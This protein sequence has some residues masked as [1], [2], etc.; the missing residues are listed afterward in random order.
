MITKTKEVY[1]CEYCKRHGLS[2]GAMRHH[3]KIC[4]ENP[5]NHRPCFRCKYL[6]KGDAIAHS[7]STGGGEYTHN[8][9]VLKCSVRNVF[10]YTPIN[11]IKGNMFNLNEENET[12]PIECNLFDTH[13]NI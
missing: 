12:M 7:E 3:E 8:V 6:T 2:K 5:N 9:S 1:Y 4:H 13:E 11:E 10:M